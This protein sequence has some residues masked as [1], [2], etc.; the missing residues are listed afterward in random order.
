[1]RKS[2]FPYALLA[3]LLCGIFYCTSAPQRVPADIKAF[4]NQTALTIKMV[5]QDSSLTPAQ[6]ETIINNL[7]SG[8]HMT[9]ESRA[10]AQTHEK[11]EQALE[12]LV[13]EKDDKLARVSVKAGRYD[14]IVGTAA[15]L[16]CLLILCAGFLIW[17]YI[18]RRA[19]SAI[20]P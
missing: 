20:T 17:R 9:K 2:R 16:A 10:Q 6:K 15:V 4:E 5:Q 11:R 1:M 7:E 19:V 12:E 14:G 18:K 8:V 13:Q 3:L